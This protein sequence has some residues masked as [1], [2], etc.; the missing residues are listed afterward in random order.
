MDGDKP[1]D[2]DQFREMATET[3]S[4]IDFIVSSLGADMEIVKMQLSE[5]FESH[6]NFARVRPEHWNLV[7]QAVLEA[8]Q[9]TLGE[10][11]WD[12]QT[13]DCWAT[14]CDYLSSMITEEI[15]VQ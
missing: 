9:E 3:A 6:E 4:L 1:S 11:K 15:L 8:L 10:A 5:T 12:T 13:A 7:G 2:R 14:T